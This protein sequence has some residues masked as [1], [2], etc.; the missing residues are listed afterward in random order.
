MNTL[1][2]EKWPMAPADA[3]RVALATVLALQG[4]L[5]LEAGGLQSQKH[6]APALQSWGAQTMATPPPVTSPMCPTWH[7]LPC[8]LPPMAHGLCHLGQLPHHMASA[9]L[10]DQHLQHVASAIL[11]FCM[12]MPHAL[13]HFDRL[14][15]VYL[16]P[17][18]NLSILTYPL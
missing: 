13:H 12:L 2:M 8:G 18:L 10:G 14:A 16:Q 7:P 11:G 1:G 3:A 5:A 6:G 17:L 4:N 15:L 9:F